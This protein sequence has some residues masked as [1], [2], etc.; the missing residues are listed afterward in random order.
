MDFVRKLSEISKTSIP[1]SVEQ[2]F[3]M[4]ILHTT[5][6][7]KEEMENTVLKLLSK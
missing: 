7:E 3:N 2:L 4:P 5:V 6:C 1:L